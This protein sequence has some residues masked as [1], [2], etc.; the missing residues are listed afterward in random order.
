MYGEHFGAGDTIGVLVDL[1]EGN[2][3]FFKNGKNLGISHNNVRGPVTPVLGLKQVGTKVTMLPFVISQPTV[4]VEMVNEKFVEMF[5]VLNRLNNNFGESVN[6]ENIPSR[7]LKESFNQLVNWR[8][9]SHLKCLTKSGMVLQVD[10]TEEQCEKI[11][12]FK[13]GDIIITPRG[14]QKIIG[15][16]NQCVWVDQMDSE[17]DGAHFWTFS[18]IESWKNNFQ[19]LEES[20]K[21]SQQNKLKMKQ[22]NQSTFS[23]CKI[24]FLFFEETLKQSKWNITFYHQ[25]VQVFND[26]SNQLNVSPFNISPYQVYSAISETKKIEISPEEFLCVASFIK[27]LNETIQSCIPLLDFEMNNKEWSIFNNFFSSK[28]IIFT[29][30]KLDFLKNLLERTTTPSDLKDDEY[31][32]PSN[33]TNIKINRNKALSINKFDQESKIKTLF[34]QTYSQL[35]KLAKESLRLAYVHPL[36]FF[37]FFFLFFSNFLGRPLRIAQNAYAKTWETE[38]REKMD[39]L[40]KQG[41]NFYFFFYF[42]LF[43]FFIYLFFFIFSFIFFY[44]YLFL[45]IF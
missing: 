12:G 18:E 26:L 19:L 38:R 21:I 1:D 36:G 34:F 6:M 13:V 29:H 30:I 3:S 40:L 5:D 23:N 8:N 15:V 25:L 22:L 16:A 24:T 2:I 17:F 39:R 45:F 14:K 33:L 7:I 20:S 35:S 32:D 9:G 37:L 27:T 11:V 42:Y 4:P 44:F 41:K 31:S 28:N 43:L 10:T